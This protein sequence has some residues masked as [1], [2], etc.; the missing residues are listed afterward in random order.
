MAKRGAKTTAK[1][2]VLSRSTPYM[3]ANAFHMQFLVLE[4]GTADLHGFCASGAIP[5]AS[6]QSITSRASPSK[7]VLL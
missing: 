2:F 4:L 6:N 1:T 5:H 7:K 3:G